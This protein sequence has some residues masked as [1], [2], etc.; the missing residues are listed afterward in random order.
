MKEDILIKAFEFGNPIKYLEAKLKEANIDT[1]DSGACVTAVIINNCKIDIYKVGDTNARIYIN[2]ELVLLT[3]DHSAMN[4]DE[5]KRK[6]SEGAKFEQEYMMHTLMPSSDGTLNIT[7]RLGS[8]IRHSMHDICVNS[9][10]MGHAKSGQ[11]SFTGTFIEHK[12]INFKDSDEVLL[13][14]S[15]DGV[16]DMFNEEENI[17]HIKSATDLVL[18]TCKR[19]HSDI[20]FIHWEGHNCE[21]C[22][23]KRLT[24][25]NEIIFSRIF[26]V[27]PDDISSVVWHKNLKVKIYHLLKKQ[28]KKQL[29]LLK[30]F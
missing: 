3:D 9:R 6:L 17:S 25:S 28:L 26:G 2:N 29:I 22:R 4:P 20:N 8:Y 5:Y 1:I 19:W 14:A 24:K 13:I 12:T 27:L 11:D 10:A 23:Q 15:S 21:A 30:V 18:L 16:W 7:K